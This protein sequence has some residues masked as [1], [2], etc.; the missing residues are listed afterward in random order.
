MKT[1]QFLTEVSRIVASLDDHGQNYC[2]VALTSYLVG[3]ASPAALDDALSRLQDYVN[4]YYA[5]QA[6]PH[7]SAAFRKMEGK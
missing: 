3:H 2:R 7:V 4:T 6:S 5:R 1:E